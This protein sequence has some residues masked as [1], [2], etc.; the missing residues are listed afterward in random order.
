MLAATA[1]F[2]N[3]VL[4][5]TYALLSL[6][7]RLAIAY[8]WQRRLEA[9]G[10]GRPLLKLPFDR[11]RSSDEVFIMG[12]GASINDYG[13]DRW[14][15]IRAHDSISMNF[16]LLHPHVPTIHVMEDIRGIRAE[17][18]RRRYMEVGDYDKVPLL[19]KTQLTNLSRE[20]VQARIA[21]LRNL[22]E[23]VLTN[24][25]LSMD[26]VA[27][28]RTVAD[29]EASNRAL[30]ALGLWRP[31]PRLAVLVK[32]GGSVSYIINLAV[33][34]GYRRIILCGVDLNHTEYFYDSRRA[35]LEAAGLPVPINDQT[36]PV[37]STN[38]PAQ[39]RIPMHQV[40]LAMKRS[41]L[42]PA[43]VEVLV[44]S[45]S[46]ALYPD[47]PSYDWGQAVSRLH[48]PADTSEV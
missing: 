40:I 18:L 32:Q 23:A 31:K 7:P 5:R 2:L 33:R 45:D 6:A 22:D 15:V 25:Y 16:F 12:T 43:G 39:K 11:Y 47:L 34:A 29:L 44:A 19:L 8:F 4:P 48:G 30:A 41:V 20:R 46:S 24:V 21:S 17:L 35:D 26:V 28:G 14:R 1:R 3:R 9:A 36:G 27:P 42:D 38:D 13:E 37:H 10:L